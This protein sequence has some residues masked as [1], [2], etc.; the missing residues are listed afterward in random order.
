[1]VFH[2]GSETVNV[3]ADLA[4]VIKRNASRL[5]EA[6]KLYLKAASLEVRP[7]TITY[8]Y[9]LNQAVYVSIVIYC[10]IYTHLEWVYC[11]V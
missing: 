3:Y 10:A 8:W 2:V 4:R 1:M 5:E 6:A 9:V 7:S 11:G